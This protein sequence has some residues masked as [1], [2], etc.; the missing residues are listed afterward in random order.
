MIFDPFAE[1][2]LNKGTSIAS[3][4][5]LKQTHLA[6]LNLDYY[7]DTVTFKTYF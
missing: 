2:F 4:D 7:E 3:V 1:K 6:L 5:N